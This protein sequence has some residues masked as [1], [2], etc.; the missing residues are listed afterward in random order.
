M[1]DALLPNMI[2]THR[3]GISSMVNTHLAIQNHMPKI[4]AAVIFKIEKAS[5][6]QF[7]YTII[8]PRKNGASEQRGIARVGE[9]LIITTAEM[10]GGPEDDEIK[11]ADDMDDDS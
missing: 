10:V 11:E 2:P 5:E 3:L 7:N 8:I 4:K 1:N 9:D 6:Y